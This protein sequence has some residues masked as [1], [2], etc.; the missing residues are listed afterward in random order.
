MPPRWCTSGSRPGRV[1]GRGAIGEQPAC[2]EG[3]PIDGRAAGYQEK[4]SSQNSV[5]LRAEGSRRAVSWL[6]SSTRRILPEIVLGRSANSMRRIRLYGA[7]RS[8]HNAMLALA[9]SGDG[10]LAAVSKIDAFGTANRAGAGDG[11]TAAS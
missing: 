9:S 8:H 4:S 5:T 1:G 6:R 11:T 7:T 10:S 2:A 3:D